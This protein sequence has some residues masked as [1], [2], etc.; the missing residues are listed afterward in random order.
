[1]SAAAREVSLRCIGALTLAMTLASR[2]LINQLN[3]SV[4]ERPQD[5]IDA[6]LIAGPLCLKPFENIMI[7]S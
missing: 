2:V 3:R 7:D 5:C 6:R 1:M 4:A